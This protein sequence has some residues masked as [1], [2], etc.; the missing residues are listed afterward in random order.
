ML[1][2]TL[3]SEIFQGFLGLCSTSGKPPFPPQAERPQASRRRKEGFGHSIKVL[4]ELLSSALIF[5]VLTNASP[6]DTSTLATRGSQVGKNIVLPVQRTISYKIFEPIPWLQ[7]PLPQ[8]Q[9]RPPPTFTG[10]NAQPPSLVKILHGFP[11]VFEMKSKLIYRTWEAFPWV[12]AVTVRL[13]AGFTISLWISGGK[14]PCLDFFS[15]QRTS[16]WNTE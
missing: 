8:W 12:R 7:S 6:E 1:K 4:F 5:P 3:S 2:F 14:R 11:N 13:R 9:S 10:I 16:S 15:S